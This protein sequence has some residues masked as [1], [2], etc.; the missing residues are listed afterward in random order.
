MTL[1]ILYFMKVN[2][3]LVVL[4]FFYKLLSREVTKRV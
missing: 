2:I 1:F 4:Y 3:A